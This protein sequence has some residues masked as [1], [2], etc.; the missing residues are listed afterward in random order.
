[1]IRVTLDVNVLASGF[2][3]EAGTPSKL[4]QRWTDLEYEL[5]LSAHILDGLERTWQKPY[6]RLRYSSQRTGDALRLLRTAATI[7]VPDATVSGVG[8]DIE[9]DLVLATAVAGNADF[10]VTGDKH[11]QE[12]GRFRG[13]TI[14]SPRQFLDWL[15]SER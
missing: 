6:F 15:Q 9:D 12:L 11:L 5:V 1:V 2:P 14:L 13:I 4:I 8:E 3:A 7:V 10:L